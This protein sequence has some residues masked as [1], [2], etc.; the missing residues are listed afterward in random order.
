MVM[1]NY[2]TT[3][4]TREEIESALLEA[5]KKK[6][7]QSGHDIVSRNELCARMFWE[8]VKTINPDF[9]LTPDNEPIIHSLI[10]Y[11]ANDPTIESQGIS[12]NKGILL[13]GPVGCGKTS[14]MK[15]FGLFPSSFNHFAIRDCREIA[16]EFMRS[17]ES[18]YLSNY[19]KLGKR[20]L[21]FCFD[22][23]GTEDTV[24]N[25]GN[26]IE[27]I[28]DILLFRYNRLPHY[29]THFTTNLSAH[30]IGDIYGERMK[31]R[32]REMVNLIAFDPKSKDM[33]R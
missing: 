17:D 20:G 4:L 21:G 10:K 8:R 3:K 6:F 24:V 27:V 18:D 9:V 28:A 1:E 14:I 12:L 19:K 5:K 22:D 25:Y 31:S 7:E 16:L 11:F 32:L 15:A 26:R 2:K 33:R 29:K 30:H 23:L 13:A